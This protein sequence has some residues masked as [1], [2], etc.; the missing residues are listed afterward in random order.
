[1]ANANV[2]LRCTK[3]KKK[4]YL[5]KDGLKIKIIYQFIKIIYRYLCTYISFSFVYIVF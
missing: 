1:M 5:N 2:L 3:E 4:F